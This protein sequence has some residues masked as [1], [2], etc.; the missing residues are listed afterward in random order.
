M[1][2]LSHISD[3]LL[4]CIG[5]NLP[6]GHWKCV[7]LTVTSN[8]VNNYL[9]G[10]E[11]SYY[12]RRQACFKKIYRVVDTHALKNRLLLLPYKPTPWPNLYTPISSALSTG[13]FNEF[14]NQ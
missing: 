3:P 2:K 11:L 7:I 5:S 8:Q 9:K 4:L 1:L 6:L 13:C 12:I 10:S 14:V